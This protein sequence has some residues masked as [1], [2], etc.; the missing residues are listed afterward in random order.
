VAKQN[1]MTVARG[2]CH[3]GQHRVGLTGSGI[4]G[5]AWCA[6]SGLAGPLPR[7]DF[8]CLLRRCRWRRAR[9]WGRPT[10]VVAAGAGVEQGRKSVFALPGLIL[11]ELR[12]RTRPAPCVLSGNRPLV[13]VGITDSRGLH[14]SLSGRPAGLVLGACP[15]DRL[16]GN[17]QPPPA[18]RAASRHRSMAGPTP[19][20]SGS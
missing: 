19:R 15:R 18:S 2:G 10:A 9:P 3:H 13:T 8:E 20:V 1:K 6:I 5:G 11:A 14:G 4:V 16:G 7:R 12:A 17:R